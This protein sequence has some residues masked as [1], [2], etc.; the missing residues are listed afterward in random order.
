MS[1]HN[2]RPWMIGEPH[3]T[4]ARKGGNYDDKLPA[5][6]P[7]GYAAILDAELDVVALVPDGPHRHADGVARVLEQA[8]ETS[9]KTRGDGRYCIML[10]L[11]DERAYAMSR[12]LEEHLKISTDPMPIPPGFDGL[13]D[14][15]VNDASTAQPNRL[16]LE[17]WEAY[18]GQ[19]PGDGCSWD[20]E[21]WEVNDETP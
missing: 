8:A 15:V 20:G 19:W 6:M 7:D 2:W 17:V 1:S 18:P 11:T 12:L 9:S 13:P 10:T 5:W 3:F 16:V 14:G 21:R 4:V